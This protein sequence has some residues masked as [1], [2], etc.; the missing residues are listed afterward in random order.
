MIG[1]VAVGM[2]AGSDGPGGIYFN[3]PQ[4]TQHLGILALSYILFSGGLE[5]PWHVVRPVLMKSL[6]LSTVGVVATAGLV[7]IVAHQMLEFT[8]LESFLI[9]SIVAATDA[10]A[11]FG[12]IRGRG[13]RLRED[14]QGILELESGTNDPMAVFLTIGLTKAVSSPDLS[15]RS[16]VPRLCL[17]LLIGGFIGFILGK[18]AAKAIPQLK[19]ESDA[20]Y[21]VVSLALVPVVYGSA[22]VL[23]GN[24]FLAVYVAGVTYGH[25][26][27][28][29]KRELVKVH[30]AVAWL[31]QVAM[32]LTLGLLV[33]PSHLPK[34]ALAGLVI[35][36]TLILVARPLAVLISLAPFKVDRKAQTLIAWAGLRGAVPIVLATYPRLAGLERSN[37]IFDIVFIVVMASALIQGTTLVPLIRRLGLEKPPETMR[38]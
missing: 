21:A 32:F 7:A 1:F 31:M 3:D 36:A 29:R 19:L 10:A 8:V 26:K 22:A 14:V 4:A 2:L 28:R 25:V 17:E 24:G 27:F 5:T 38:G 18:V 15:M 9:G 30:D 13:V 16:L 35:A 12:I 20:L 23:M 34:V 6:A 37:E 33:F 11:V